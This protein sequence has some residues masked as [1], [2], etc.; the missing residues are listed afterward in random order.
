[1]NYNPEIHNRKSYRLKNY[2]Y[3]QNGFY[4]VT[5]LSY[6][7][8]HLFGEIENKRLE[9]T[10][11]ARI[12]KH[13]WLGIPNHYPSVILHE[14]IIMPN[15]IHGILEISKP[16]SNIVPQPSPTVRAQ[17]F[18]PLPKHTVKQSSKHQ[19]QKQSHAPWEP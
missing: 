13:F 17:D 9:P 4:F 1:M 8:Q 16:P 5:I 19:F 12:A 11:L 2:D 14:Y 18:E 3:S 6:Q 10:Q 7:R 15:H